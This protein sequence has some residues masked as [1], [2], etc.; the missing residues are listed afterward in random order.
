MSRRAPVPATA[1]KLLSLLLQYPDER[2]ISA[3]DEI[4]AAAGELP[5]GPRAEAIHRFLASWSVAPPEELARAYVETFD[6]RRKTSLYLT[7]HLYGDTRQRGMALVRLRRMYAAGGLD[8]D[9]RELP[10]HLP[11]ILEFASLARP[12]YGTAVLRELRPALEIVRQAL[13]ERRSPY[14]DL[15]DAVCDGLPRPSPAEWA[16]VR[17]LAAE[18]PPVERVGLEPFA[19]PEVVPQGGG[20]R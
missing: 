4:V 18:G 9:T 19:P 11:V 17:R 14:A 7:Y 5:P 3:R 1:Y 20:R 12:G 16:A 10:D 15:L 2:I 8:L 6:L 13:R